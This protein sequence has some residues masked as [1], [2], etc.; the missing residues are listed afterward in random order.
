MREAFTK[1]G[2]ENLNGS[3]KEKGSSEE[4]DQEEVRT[5]EGFGG[6]TDPEKSKSRRIAIIGLGSR[7]AEESVGHLDGGKM[8][9]VA[10]GGN[11]PQPA[12]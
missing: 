10:G 2:G 5:P 12:S 3:G 7:S 11:P 1:K 6:R 4:G 9:P 8:P